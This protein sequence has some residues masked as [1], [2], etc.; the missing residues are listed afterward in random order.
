MRNTKK[1]YIS[2]LTAQNWLKCDKDTI[3]RILADGLVEHYIDEEQRVK[4]NVESLKRF[5]E[6]GAFERYRPEPKPD[7]IIIEGNDYEN[8]LIAGVDKDVLHQI[9]DSE[10]WECERFRDIPL[11]KEQMISFIHGYAPDFDC[12][13]APYLINGWFYIARSNHWVKKFKYKPG[14]DGLFHLVSMYTTE[15]EKGRNLLEEI[16]CSGYFR[17]AI[18]DDRLRDVFA[19]SRREIER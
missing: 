12:R 3:K 13:Y 15:K 7:S 19:Q 16:I 10:L 8:S 4:V 5:I 18:F 9:Q 11:T 17:P 14:E 6:S 1:E 2:R